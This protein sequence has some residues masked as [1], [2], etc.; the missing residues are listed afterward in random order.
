MESTS[1]NI[2]KRSQPVISRI[3]VGIVDFPAESATGVGR[4][5]CGGEGEEAAVELRARRT[6][7]AAVFSKYFYFILFFFLF[8]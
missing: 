1:S 7:E 8:E 3:Q 5:D 4:E 6:S 2:S